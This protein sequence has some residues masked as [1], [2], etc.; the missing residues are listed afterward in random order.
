MEKVP[1]ATGTPTQQAELTRLV[2]QILTAKRNGDAARVENL[3]AE[4]DTRVYALYGITPVEITLI[5]GNP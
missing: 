2:D 3:E 4:I 5:K 1:I